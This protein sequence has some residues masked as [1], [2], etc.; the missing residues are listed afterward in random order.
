MWKHLSEL[1]RP[2]PQDLIPITSAEVVS[3]D[4][5]SAQNYVTGFWVHEAGRSTLGTLLCP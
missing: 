3:G 5:R 2:L 4:A 1:K